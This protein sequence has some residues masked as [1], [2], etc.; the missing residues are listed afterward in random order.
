MLTVCEFRENRSREDR[1]FPMGE[2]YVYTICVFKVGLVK[3][4][5]IVT[6]S[7]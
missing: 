2:K 1:M 4:K 3:V 5:E 6:R 7:E